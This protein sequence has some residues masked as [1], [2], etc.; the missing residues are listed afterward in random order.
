MR[1]KRDWTLPEALQDLPP[2]IERK[3]ESWTIFE[4]P[5]L[6]TQ[7]LPIQQI[8]GLTYEEH[9]VVFDP[10]LARPLA[11]SGLPPTIT[12][13]RETIQEI[14]KRWGIGMQLPTDFLSSQW[15]RFQFQMNLQK[16][17]EAVIDTQGLLIVNELMTCKSLWRE[18]HWR[19]VSNLTFHS[20]N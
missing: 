20:E 4:D 16:M 11:E 12:S 14:L 7:I 13:R 9:K 2:L 1:N 5:N 10:V 8:P 6:F 15:G 3:F 18:F 19:C 17:G